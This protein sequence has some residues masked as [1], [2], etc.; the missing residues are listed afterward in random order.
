[1]KGQI[2]TLTMLESQTEHQQACGNSII[3]RI[4]GQQNEKE[5]KMK[6]VNLSYL[7]K[8]N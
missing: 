5:N 3:I 7:F 8:L 6:M 1:M 4:K 2:S